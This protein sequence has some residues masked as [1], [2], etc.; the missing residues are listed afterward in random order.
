MIGICNSAVLRRPQLALALGAL[1][2]AT[3]VPTAGQPAQLAE[4]NSAPAE[5]PPP[6]M[7]DPGPFTAFGRLIDESISGLAAGFDGARKS[8]DEAASRAGE[9]ARSA[10]VP[11][12]L[13]PAPSLPR[14]P[15][16]PGVVAGREFCPPA[17]NGAP[18]CRVAS[19]SLCR[20][21]GFNDGRSIDMQTE[22]KCPAELW[23]AGRQPTENECVLESYVTR[24]LCQ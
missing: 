21:K 8:V 9:A 24:A 22:Q 12:L 13:P 19:A 20:A 10:P 3:L 2:L 14:L 18:D 16:P 5:A 1:L 4:P 7:P 17:P 6:R 11:P 15:A 23:A